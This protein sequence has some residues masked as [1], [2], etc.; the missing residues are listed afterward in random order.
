MD[1]WHD[2]CFFMADSAKQSEQSSK[3]LFSS[4]YLNIYICHWIKLLLFRAVNFS[5]KSKEN[6]VQCF[7]PY[8]M[9]AGNIVCRL[10][11]EGGVLEMFL[12]DKSRKIYTYNEI[13][14]LFKSREDIQEMFLFDYLVKFLYTTK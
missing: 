3:C 2:S 6:V 14:F 10:L 7:Q 4:K 11:W 1:T 12:L 5:T 9:S 13:I 8:N